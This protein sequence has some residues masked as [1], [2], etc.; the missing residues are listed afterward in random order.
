VV[1]AGNSSAAS[2]A[3]QVALGA[4][5]EAE[6]PLAVL[7]ADHRRGRSL[8]DLRHLTE[9]DDLALFDDDGQPQQGLGREAAVAREAHHSRDALRPVI[10]SRDF[11]TLE[12]GGSGLQQR[13]PRHVEPAERRVVGHQ[14]PARQRPAGVGRHGDDS[15]DRRE[16]ALDL[17]LALGE[18]RQIGVEEL[19]LDIGR[20]TADALGDAHAHRS[21]QLDAEGQVLD[22]LGED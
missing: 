1:P 13:R 11:D 21:R 9:L 5:V 18:R 17:G 20:R 14:A 8:G 10:E 19:D 3:S 15:R 16:D 4:H 6:P 12:G 7:A 22:L 2:G